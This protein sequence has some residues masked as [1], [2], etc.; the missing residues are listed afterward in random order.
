[1]N[2][3]LTSV[4]SGLGGAVIGGFFSLTATCITLEKQYK[5]DKKLQKIRFL[6]ED[7]NWLRQN[8]LELFIELVDVLESYHLP[9]VFEKENTDFGYVDKTEIENYINATNEYIEE[10]KGKLSLFLPSE[11][12][13]QIVRLR[14]KMC[15]IAF[16][17]ESQKLCYSDP[18]NNE[19]FETIIEAKKISLN[20]KRL[21]GIDDKEKK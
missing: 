20:I 17:N 1:M 18:K 6:E 4:L 21:L 5:K 8:R 11:I 3:Y 9:L 19:M 14:G 12:Y 15:K 7:K 16:S 10:N 2:E 13:S